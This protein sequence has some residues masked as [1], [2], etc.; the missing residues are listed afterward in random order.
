[1]SDLDEVASMAEETL[2]ANA[3]ATDDDD[4]GC[5]VYLPGELSCYLPDGSVM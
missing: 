4:T 1:M 2:G 5:Q 3:A